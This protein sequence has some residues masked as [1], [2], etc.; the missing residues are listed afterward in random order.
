MDDK[1]PVREELDFAYLLELL[2]PL[3]NTDGFEGLAELFSIIGHEK[4]LTLCKYAGG[5]Y[6]KIP[7]LDE[8]DQAIDG[9][10]YFYDVHIAKTKD[11]T[12]VP[13]IVLPTFFRIVNIYEERQK[14]DAKQD[15]RRD[16]AS[17]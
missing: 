5:E 10:Q 8:L 1:I 4:L 16:K 6:F 17:Q 13:M 11:I 15:Q 2:P 7:T 12:E 3:Y 14:K 9:L